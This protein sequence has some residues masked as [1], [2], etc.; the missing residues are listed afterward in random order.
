MYLTL[1]QKRKLTVSIGIIYQC[2]YYFEYS[3]TAIS[4]IYY[5]K[6]SFNISD[7]KFYYACSMASIFISAVISNYMCGRIMDKTRD[8]RRIVLTLSSVNIIG[9]LTYTLTLSPWLSVFGRFVCGIGTGIGAAI[10]G[11]TPV[12]SCALS[13]ISEITGLSAKRKFLPDFGLYSREVHKSL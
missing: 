4:A 2:L 5:Y 6:N 12:A 9:N 13:N 10:T 3:S 7:P 1:N 11:I 8:L